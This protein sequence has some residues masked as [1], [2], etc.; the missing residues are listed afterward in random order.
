MNIG[1]A[2]HLRGE[3]DSYER[4]EA[5]WLLEHILEL[6][7]ASILNKQLRKNESIRVWRAQ[8][9]TIYLGLFNT[10]SSAKT[11]TVSIVD[12]GGSNLTQ[13]SCNLVEVWSGEA[14]GTVSSKTSLEI[15]VP[16]HDVALLRV[17]T[18]LNML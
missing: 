6:N 18:C 9:S 8:A 4:Q 10:G 1:Q 15:R 16:V 17:T 13:K 2:L 11:E 14:V 5:M 12:I 7:S 3:S